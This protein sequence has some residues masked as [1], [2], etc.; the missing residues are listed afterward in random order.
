VAARIVP[1]AGGGDGGGSIR[2]PAS[3]CGL[4]GLKPS[5]GSTP[6][7]PNFGEFWR[8]Y[9]QEHVLTRSVRDSAAVLDALWGAD[10]GAPGR[11][12]IAFTAT[13]F[14]GSHVHDD[15]RRALDDAVRLLEE[16]GHDVSEATPQFDGEAFAIAFV[17]VI[18]AEAR[19]EIE[20]AAQA[21]G[22]APRRADFEAT[23]WGLGL[24][25]K[26]TSASA[27]ASAACSMQMAGR[28]IG[29]F[30]EEYDVL[31]TPTLA[32]PPPLIGELQPSRREMLLMKAI[33]RLR[34]GW[35]LGALD[36]I[37]PLAE[38][39]LAFIPYTPV[40]NVTG[41]PAMSVPLF[42]N[43]AGLPVGVH[44]AARLGAE[45]TLFQLAG[46]LERARPWFDRAPPNL[47]APRGA[48]P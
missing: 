23:T 39:T 4:F 1:M 11:L 47:V 31:L 38:K 6:T 3:C 19:A 36:V 45:A 41:Q 7:G 22:R 17:T 5:R 26:A 8:G 33:A 34:A 29:R 24:V 18:A 42:W 2:I 44:F 14:L 20:L 21:A 16:L 12:R 35:L 46:Q 25:G 43:D 48:R 37:K 13:P 40:F 28:V 10:P 30:L 32:D 27:Y 9:V 15:C